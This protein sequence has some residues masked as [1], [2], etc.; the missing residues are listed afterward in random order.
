MIS[1]IN[2]NKSTY[3]KFSYLVKSAWCATLLLGA[4]AITNASSS[5]V[6]FSV[7]M[8]VQL[9]LGTFIP[10]T[11]QVSVHGT[12]NNFGTFVLTN[13]P[14]ASNTNIYQGTVVDTTNP[15]GSLETYKFYCTDAS[16]GWENPLNS[17]GK[18]RSARLPSN[19][20][21]SLVLPTVFFDDA[22]LQST[23]QVTFQV[24]MAQQINLGNFNPGT[25]AAYVRSTANGWGLSWPLT[26][27]PTILTTNTL[28]LVTSNVY[29][30][31]YAVATGT[32]SSPEFKYEYEPAGAWESPSATNQVGGGDGNRSF[33]DTN[34]QILPIVNYNDQPYAPIATNSVTFQVDMTAQTLLGNFTPG[35]SVNVLG[36]FNGWVVG[37]NPLTN[38]LSA[39][40]TNIYSA[41]IG[42]TNSLNATEIY[43]FTFGTGPVYESSSPKFTTLDSGPNDYNR[44]FYLPNGPTLVLPVVNFSDVGINDLLQTDTAVTFTVNMN[45]AVGTDLHVFNPSVDAVYLNG[46]FAN[47]NGQIGNWYPWLGG[48]NPVTAPSGFQMIETSPTSGIYTNTLIIPKGTSV[49]FDYKY[50]MDIG[51]ANQDPADDEA[52][53]GNNHN[54]VVRSTAT[55]LYTMPPDTFGNQ[56][57][58]P[59]FYALSKASGNLTVGAPSGGVV[60]VT[61]LGRPGA[62]LQVN[63]SLVGS[64]WQDLVAT[65]GTN[66]TVGV[67]STNG[68]VSKTNWPASNKAFFRLVKP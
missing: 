41:V 66:W 19:S 52:I 48:V 67:V 20:G 28:G 39:V 7:D 25:D 10:G 53:S 50:G 6:T 54:R 38:N 68:F 1:S 5:I 15:N 58:E 42:I 44:L 64:T 30:G 57:H 14:S 32:N 3:M 24:D 62:H 33:L 26:N 2:D 23:N 17:S 56:Y 46:P 34:S 60:P 37:S 13:N 4:T 55:G 65:D 61:W 63:T 59:Y 11:D 29:V 9:G 12:F 16:L 18:N 27:N 22:G 21:G 49:D 40:N 8:S 47:Y 43:K 51:S 31:T 36:A 35:M 45:G